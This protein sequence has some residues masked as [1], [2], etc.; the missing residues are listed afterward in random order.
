M[1]H[2]FRIFLRFLWHRQRLF[3]L[4]IY[5]LP[6][7]KWWS[8]REDEVKPEYVCQWFEVGW[9]QIDWKISWKNLRT[10][11]Q[12]HLTY[13][14]RQGNMF[15]GDLQGD[16]LNPQSL[17]IS[18]FGSFLGT[19]FLCWRECAFCSSGQWCEVVWNMD[20]P[21]HHVDGS[22]GPHWPHYIITG[23][24]RPE[25]ISLIGKRWGFRWR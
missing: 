22:R 8:M 24:K 5:A 18:S 17:T 1:Y 15:A 20:P 12:C 4:T 7:T 21:P 9:I 6:I 3:N 19:F 10:G 25:L 14:Q 2:R 13:Y 11:H 16:F 23:S